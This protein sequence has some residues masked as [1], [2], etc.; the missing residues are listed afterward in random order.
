MS[1]RSSQQQP[2]KHS[3]VKEKQSLHFYH[4]MDFTQDQ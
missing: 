4:K 2:E 3:Q 1:S